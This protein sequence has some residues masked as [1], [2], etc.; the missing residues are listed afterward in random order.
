MFVE[1]RFLQIIHHDTVDGGCEGILE[2]QAEQ[3]GIEWVLCFGI[4][5]L[6]M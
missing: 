3:L 2:M 1:Q 5:D 6:E 4:P